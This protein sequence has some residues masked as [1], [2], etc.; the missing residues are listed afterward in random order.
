[1]RRT[2]I[3]D[4]ALGRALADLDLE[5]P[6]TPPLAP[7]V[8]V[9]L[10][11]D[12]AA[13]VRPPF[14]RIAIWSRRRALVLAAVGVL[15]LL[16]LAF[17][18]RF[19][20]GAVEV[21]VRPGASVSGPP[22]SAEGLGEAV[23][24]ADVSA[25]AGFPVRFPPGSPPDAAYLVRTEAGRGALLVWDATGGAPALPGTRW[26]LALLELP[27]DREIVVKDVNRYEDLRPV[28]VLGRP[29]AW[30][31]APHEL[32]VFTDDGPRTYA[33]AANV[34]IWTRNGVTLRLETTLGLADALALAQSMG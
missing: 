33:I 32:I 21:R 26:R 6:R 9:R 2:P 23:P 1:M 30:I 28:E 4:E 27:S 3:P 25:A 34:L 22:L 20:L 14:P 10:E 29:A 8:V 13:R 24:V 5:F 17:G 19:V 18:A 15:A 11:A 16:A 31:D 7:A 12:R